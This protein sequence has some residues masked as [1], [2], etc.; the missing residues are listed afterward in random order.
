[1]VVAL[2]V[3]MDPFPDAAFDSHAQ[4]QSSSAPDAEAALSA[5]SVFRL[6]Q[7]GD[8]SA[9]QLSDALGGI[10]A[11]AQKLIKDD[12]GVSFAKFAAAVKMDQGAGL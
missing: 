6:W 2:P 5:H 8:V 3:K 9:G 7:G 11:T 10:G 1:M 12:P 4:I